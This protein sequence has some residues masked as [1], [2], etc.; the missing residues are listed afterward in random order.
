MMK[1]LGTVNFKGRS[2][3]HYKFDAYPLH[4]V[5]DEGLAGVYVVTDRKR[6]KSKPGFRHIRLATGHSDDLR[7]SLTNGKDAFSSKGAN[8]FCL[9]AQNNVEIRRNIEEDL[10]RKPRPAE[11]V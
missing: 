4:M 11:N 6:C 5:L 10:M 3:N 9:Y 8:C 1:K 7:M 2:G